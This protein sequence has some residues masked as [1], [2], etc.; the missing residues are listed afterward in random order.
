[1]SVPVLL[2]VAV[3][4]MRVPASG[5]QQDAFVPVPAS[6]FSGT[7]MRIPEWGFSVESPDRFRP[8]P[9]GDRAGR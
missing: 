3:L 1:M 5:A 4:V 9:P 2:A 8:S 7:V 6:A